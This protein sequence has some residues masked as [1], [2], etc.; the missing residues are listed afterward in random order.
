[1]IEW[2]PAKGATFEEGKDYLV[3]DGKFANVAVYDPETFTWM[4][5]NIQFVSVT[6]YA[7][8]NLPWE[9]QT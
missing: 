9:E 1:M 5:H 4:R 3:T 8:I 6:H 7:E 2:K